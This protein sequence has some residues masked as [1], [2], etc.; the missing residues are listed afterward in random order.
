MNQKGLSLLESL[1]TM[2][3]VTGVML[4]VAQTLMVGAHG[5]H[6]VRSRSIVNNLAQQ[7]LE[8]IRGQGFLT[9]RDLIVRTG[10][11]R[12]ARTEAMLIHPTSGAI[13]PLST[14]MA[15]SGSRLFNIREDLTYRANSPLTELDDQIDVVVR[16]SPNGSSKG[17]VLVATLSRRL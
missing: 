5:T 17:P 14:G 9:N 11:T 12:F 10:S 2:V 16:V 13:V 7:R 15:A 6:L 3:I 4:F 8:K 1:A